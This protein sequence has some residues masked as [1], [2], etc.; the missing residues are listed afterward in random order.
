MI[1]SL[2]EPIE[3]RDNPLIKSRIW[4]IEMVFL[5]ASILVISR[6]LSVLFCTPVLTTSSIKL[7][8]SSGSFPVA[9]M[10]AC[11]P[12]ISIHSF[13]VCLGVIIELLY[14]AV[15]FLSSNL[16]QEVKSWWRYKQRRVGSDNSSA[17]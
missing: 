7:L 16:G 15:I 10:G 13:I 1:A 12:A 4:L 14:M 11:S 5:S 6:L 8:I 17:G 9:I 3:V 2:R